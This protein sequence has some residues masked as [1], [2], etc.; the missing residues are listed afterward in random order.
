LVG[1]YFA[2]QHYIPARATEE[3]LADVSKWFQIIYAFVLVLGFISV[4]RAH[5]GK[6]RRKDAGW[7]YSIV[8]FCA[9]VV[10]FIVGALNEGNATAGPDEV[11]A[12]SYG[13]SFGW[14]YKYAM[15]TLAMT[16]FATLAFYVASAAFRAFRAKN[17]GATMLMLFALFLILGKIPPGEWAWAQTF[18]SFEGWPVMSDIVEWAMATLNM[19]AQRAILIGVALGMIAMSM[20]IILGIERTYLGGRG[21]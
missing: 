2:F 8:L 3:I 7:G 5:S 1:V 16:M 15:A 9:I 18:G 17:L 6:I 11:G 20:K 21:E 4:T 19:P 12:P 10:M 14:M 13:N